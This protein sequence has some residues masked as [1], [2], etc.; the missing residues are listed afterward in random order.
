[1][2]N[3]AGYI[4]DEGV[5]FNSVTDSTSRPLKAAAVASAE[6][7]AMERKRDLQLPLDELHHRVANHFALLSGYVHM[8]S[9]DLIRRHVTPDAKSIQLLLEAIQIQINTVAQL[10]RFMATKGGDELVNIAEHLHK[11]L[12]PFRSDTFGI[13]LLE[14]DF[15]EGCLVRPEELLPMSQIVAEVVTNAIKHG[16]SGETKIKV[17]CR[18]YAQTGLLLEIAD[19]GPRLPELV[20]PASCKSVGLRLLRALAEQLS[21]VVEFKSGSTGLLFRLFLPPHQAGIF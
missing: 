1:M 3:I 15:M 2:P 18:T 17:S 20:D 8:Q 12:E 9:M 21:A 5:R 7:R 19:N 16:K 6:A 4:F 13:I 10:H 14:E 11:I